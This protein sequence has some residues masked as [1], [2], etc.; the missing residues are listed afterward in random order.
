MSIKR[1]DC[2]SVGGRQADMIVSAFEQIFLPAGYRKSGKR[3]HYNLEEVMAEKERVE[4]GIGYYQGTVKDFTPITV[5][6]DFGALE[7]LQYLLKKSS[8][9]VSHKVDVEVAKAA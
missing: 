2:E 9:S 8:A 3:E 7:R 5:S 4:G 6:A 1:N